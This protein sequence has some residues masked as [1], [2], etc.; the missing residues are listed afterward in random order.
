MAISKFSERTTI[1]LNGRYL[2]MF[3]EEIAREERRPSQVAAD[4][5]KWAL[6]EKW[7]RRHGKK[8]M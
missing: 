6:N 5:I 1:T 3:K 8:R 4:I 2:K 7:E